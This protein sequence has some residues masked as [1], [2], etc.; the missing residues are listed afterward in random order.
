[1]KVERSKDSITLES[2]D[3][4]VGADAAR[5]E[6]FEFAAA[7]GRDHRDYLLDLVGPPRLI[8]PTALDD[9]WVFALIGSR[10]RRRR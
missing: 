10:F 7:A 9:S 5:Y 4:I 8:D 3:A 2:P 1:V 6:G